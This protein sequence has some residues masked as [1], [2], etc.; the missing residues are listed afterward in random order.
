MQKNRSLVRGFRASALE[1]AWT[2]N[3]TTRTITTHQLEGLPDLHRAVA[4]ALIQKGTWRLM[5]DNPAELLERREPDRAN[6]R[7]Q[8]RRT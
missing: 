4:M 6:E 5:G 7:T 1:P 8:Q 2:N 3:M